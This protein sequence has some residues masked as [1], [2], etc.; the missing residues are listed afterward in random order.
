[1]S[2]HNSQNQVAR[3][4]FYLRKSTPVW[5]EGD[6]KIIV[7]NKQLLVLMSF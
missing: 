1:L 7:A 6:G 4:L 2:S 5:K 3:V